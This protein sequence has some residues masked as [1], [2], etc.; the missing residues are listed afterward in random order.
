MTGECWS[1][2]EVVEDGIEEKFAEPVAILLLVVVEPQVDQLALDRLVHQQ[3]VGGEVV[4]HHR[5]TCFA[6]VGH[7]SFAHKML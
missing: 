7:N 6:K 4:L 1:R 2:R 3:D 5:T